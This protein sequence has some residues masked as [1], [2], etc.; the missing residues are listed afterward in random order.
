MA[1]RLIIAT[2]VTISFAP[3]SVQYLHAKDYPT[4]PIE[5]IVPFGAGGSLDLEARIT[6]ENAKKYLGQP[7]VVLN[8]VG[9]GGTVGATEVVRSKPDGYKLLFYAS[10]YFATTI[11]AQNVSFDPNYLVPLI[12]FAEERSGFVVKGDAPWKTLGE[13]LDYG[14][15]NP[16]KLRWTHTGRGIAPHINQLLLFRRAGVD[17]IDIPY[18]SSTEQLAAVLGGHTDGSSTI[19][20]AAKENYRSGNLKFLVTHSTRRYADTSSIPCQTELGFPNPILMYHGFF[21]HRD[22]PEDIKKN[23]FDVLKKTY[24]DPEFKKQAE[25]IGTELCFGG[26][27]FLR[28]SIK[29]AEEVG[30]PILKE[31][32][33]YDKSWDSKS[34]IK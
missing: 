21:I 1:R 20:V 15:Q 6:A 5:I 30:V 11:K 24:D 17:T 26:A 18:K 3:F 29:K 10:T 8:K 23:L 9:A 4:K 16:G 19:Y 7:M 2:L 27:E 28:D 33:L 25:Q 12:N 34:G 31:V 13:L 32:G 14:K 22:T